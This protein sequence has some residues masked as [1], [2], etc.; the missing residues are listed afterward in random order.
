MAKIPEFTSCELIKFTVLIAS[1]GTPVFLQYLLGRRYLTVKHVMNPQCT[2]RCSLVADR[3]GGLSYRR[4]HFYTK[5]MPIK[6]C[7]FNETGKYAQTALLQPSSVFTELHSACDGELLERL[8][9]L[10]FIGLGP[11]W[12]HCT[13][14]SLSG[15]G[16]FRPSSP[17][18]CCRLT[19]ECQEICL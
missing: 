2:V 10:V 3:Y 5:M 14:L 11:F 18:G 4:L 12:W 8:L 19:Y 16:M 6:S 7:L 17:K 15:P 1:P 13:P 9:G